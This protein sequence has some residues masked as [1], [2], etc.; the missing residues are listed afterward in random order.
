MAAESEAP[1]E[2]TYVFDLHSSRQG[3][4]LNKMCMSLTRPE[5]RDEFTADPRA[6]MRKHNV[7]EEQIAAVEAHDWLNLI[8][9]GGNVY[10]LIKVGHL[11]GDGLYALGAQQR[12]ETLEQFLDTRLVRGAR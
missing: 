8:K 1:I 2:G 6:Y 10:M 12:G 4:A 3:Y 5:N 9:A 11:L 7:A